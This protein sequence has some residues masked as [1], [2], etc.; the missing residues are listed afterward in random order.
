MAYVMLKASMLQQE[1]E[2][3]WKTLPLSQWLS[4][5]YGIPE[6][7]LTRGLTQGQPN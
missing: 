4:D 5:D 3:D 1:P 2:G 6:G 7:F